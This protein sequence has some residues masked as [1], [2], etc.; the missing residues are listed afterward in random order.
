MADKQKNVPYRR[1]KEFENADAWE[2]RKFD[3]CFNFPVS[4]NS[5]S[6]ALLNYDEG[7]IK[8]V[9]YGDILI[10]Y[11]AIL[12]IKNDKIPYITGGKLEKYKSSL[13]ENGDLIFADAAEDETVG[14]AVE[15][16]GLTEKNL[17]AGLHTIVA[18]SKDK[19]AE[20]F[21]GYYINS[22]TYHR[23]LLRLIQGSK[24][25]S[26]SKGN[27]QKTLVSFPK[28]FEEQQKI[29]S[30]FKKI[31]ETIA[32]HQRKYDKL[33]K[34]KSAYLTEMFPAEGERKPKRRF[35]GFT[36]D[37]EE[38]KLGEVGKAKSGIGFPDAQQGGKQGTPFYKVSD[39]NNPGNEVV[40]M[41]AN[42]YASDSQLK[43]NKWN[44]INPQ[45]SGVVFAKVGA[46]I[47]LD[48]KRIVDTSFL[49]DNN[50]MSYLFDSSWNRY[51]GK[52]LFEK[53]RLSR[54]AQVGALP[55]FNGSDVE[56]IKVMIPEE[57][58]Q[59]VI[60]DMFEKLDDTIAL[61]Q[62][63]LEKLQNLKQAYLNEMFV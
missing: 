8:S 35:S 16:N 23:Q 60:G 29:G 27:L 30:F 43:E 5:L 6:R 50:M 62:Q 21:L 18:R 34:L 58:E 51:F 25:S 15:V 4:T 12:N 9:H 31:D 28:D 19:K 54:F 10:K 56:D 1:F 33:K 59:K 39:M 52:T 2:Q 55:S 26:I 46:A 20:F 17:V 13:L 63:Q 61:H 22:N 32:L 36:D 7:D 42:N 57:S 44:P 53:L 38:R 24:V 40:M 45:N 48:R 47:F 14:K 11:P 37:W 3:E 49:I 41:N